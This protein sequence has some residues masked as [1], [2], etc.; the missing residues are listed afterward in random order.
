MEATR[1]EIILHFTLMKKEKP[2]MD[3]FLFIIHVRWMGEEKSYL[4][5]SAAES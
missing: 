1:A 2:N 4:K 5:H 3:I